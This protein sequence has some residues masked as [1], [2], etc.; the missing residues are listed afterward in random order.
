MKK[1]LLIV[2]TVFAALF[3]TLSFAPSAV[4]Y[5]ET[6]CNVEVDAQIVE[7]GSDF[8]VSGTSH[9]FTT[10]ERRAGRAAADA[11]TWKVTFNGQ[12]RNVTGESFSVTF[13]AP[14]VDKRTVLHL[15]ASAIMP[16]AAANCTKSVDITV[17][18]DDTD[19]EGP[20]LP[21][22]GG[23]RLIILLAGLALV[24]AGAFAVRRGRKHA[25]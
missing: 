21:N 10:G 13:R 5:P 23:P 8:T 25:A 2:A 12:V 22:T 19:V 4:A 6:S 24:G 15:T 16:D 11:V 20:D 3:A 7:S 18:P 1:A 9:Q 14:I 17:V